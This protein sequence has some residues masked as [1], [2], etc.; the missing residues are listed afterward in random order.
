MPLETVFALNPVS[1]DIAQIGSELQVRFFYTHLH[2]YTNRDNF[3]VLVYI[4]DIR[5]Y[6][7]G[8]MIASCKF[9]FSTEGMK[10][11]MCL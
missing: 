11:K 3:S 7:V 6:Y 4:D 1:F 10:Y 9:T 2:Q 5:Q 8:E